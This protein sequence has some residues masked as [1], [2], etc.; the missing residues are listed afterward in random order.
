MPSAP[1]LGMVETWRSVEMV[2]RCPGAM[3]WRATTGMLFRGSMATAVASAE[4][5][6][7]REPNQ[8]PNHPRD[9][10]DAGAGAGADE[11]GAPDAPTS[12]RWLYTLKMPCLP[13]YSSGTGQSP[14][15]PSPSSRIA[16]QGAGWNPPG[17]GPPGVPA[18]IAAAAAGD[19]FAE[20]ADGVDCELPIATGASSS[21]HVRARARVGRWADCRGIAT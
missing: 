20:A 3:P 19:A 11:T 7:A 9:A 5:A 17:P 14:P 18:P 2:R 8:P 6:P 15:D 10:E 1:D 4:E 21:F 16:A 13:R 12:M